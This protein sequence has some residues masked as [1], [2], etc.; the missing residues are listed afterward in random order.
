MKKLLV[1]LLCAIML[2]TCAGALAEENGLQTSGEFVYEVD[3]KYVYI[4]DYNLAEGQT[5]LFVPVKIDGHRVQDVDVSKLP[6]SVKTVYCPVN[7]S[8]EGEL[9]EG[10]ELIMIRYADYDWVQSEEWWSKYL[11]D[12]GEDDYVLT[13][14]YALAWKDGELYEK[15]VES[16]YAEELPTELAGHK[17]HIQLLN[18]ECVTYTSGDWQYELDTYDNTLKAKLKL[19]AS[20]GITELVIPEQIDGYEVRRFAI[21]GIP[22]TV[23]TVYM[24]KGLWFDQNGAERDLVIITYEDYAS[25]QENEWKRKLV[26]D[27]T[28][29]DLALTYPQLYKFYDGGYDSNNIHVYAADVPTELQGKRCLNAIDSG[30]VWYTSGDWTYAYYDDEKTTVVIKDVTVAEGQTTLFVP[31]A[32]EGARVQQVEGNIADNHGVTLFVIPNNCWVNSY[33]TTSSYG[34]LNYIDRAWVDGRQD[35]YYTEKY[36]WLGEKDLSVEDY[37][38]YANGESTKDT[39][40]YKD[41][42]TELNG[43]KITNNMYFDGNVTV[44]K[45]DDYSYVILA[46]DTIAITKYDNELAKS[47]IIPARI[48]GKTVTALMGDSSNWV[49][50]SSELTSLELPST[51]KMIGKRAIYAWSLKALEI[52][53]GVTEIGESAIHCYKVSSIKLPEG[54]TKLGK[55]WLYGKTKSITIPD[56]V[57]TLDAYAFTDASYIASIKVPDTVTN[58]GVGAFSGMYK[59]SKLTLPETMV[60]IPEKLAASSERLAKISIP[61]ATQV[62]GK[63]AFANC[64][65]LATVTFAKNDAQIKVIGEGA[66][67]GT[68]LGKIALPESLTTISK[69]AFQGCTKLSSVTMYDNIT[70]IDRYAFMGCT[71]LTK[72]SL[73]EGLTTISEGAFMGCKKL[74]SVTI[75]ASVTAIE[76]FAFEGCSSKLTVTTTEGS[77]AQQWAEQ[78]GYKVKIAK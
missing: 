41:I 54:V 72:I 8:W 2:L 62:I 16:F 56:S 51:L 27:M 11:S 45:K 29:D 55:K 75:P 32:I 78:N 13:W 1:A 64:T 44:H 70:T 36:A 68:A 23:E 61:A 69:E 52:P 30:S 3:E 73:S 65:K 43:Y 14:A 6:E 4:V 24:K 63:Q 33:N 60:E 53:D 46:D 10:R 26:P 47:L 40:E 9:A 39:I 5:E 31:Y 25:I 74:A 50:N 37:T 28:E 12:M 7:S 42:P 77:F 71:K 67:S 57:T 76:D 34:V 49:I 20:E 59:L 38:H 21:P 58:V 15:E 19:C 66:F 17:V 48:D 35:D 18:N 22:A